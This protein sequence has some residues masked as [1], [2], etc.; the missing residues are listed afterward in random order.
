MGIAMLLYSRHQLYN[1]MLLYSRHQ[2]YND[3]SGAPSKRAL[4]PR[5]PPKSIVSKLLH[6][7][8]AASKTS[9]AQSLNWVSAFALPKAGPKSLNSFTSC[10]AILWKWRA[11]PGRASAQPFCRARHRAHAFN[12][13]RGRAGVSLLSPKADGL[14][15]F[16][17]CQWPM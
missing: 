4:W 8:V 15:V 11:L 2:L 6:A 1:A 13:K 10:A 9:G 16:D 5:R 7:T 3:P 14:S 17:I 12:N